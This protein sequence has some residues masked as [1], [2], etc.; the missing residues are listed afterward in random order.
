MSLIL[1]LG[2]TLAFSWLLAGRSTPLVYAG[3]YPVTNTDAGGLGSLRRAILDA[4]A[5]P[6]PDTITFDP[7]VTGTIVL[8][9]ALPPIDDDLTIAGPGMSHLDVSGDDAHRVFEIASG[10]AVT[11]TGLTVRDGRVGP[12]N[13]GGI[14][15]AGWLYLDSVRVVSN[16]ARSPS[17]YSRGAGIYVW[18]GS[19]TLIRTQ[20]VSNSADFGGGIYVRTGA[21]DCSG[22]AIEG[23][24][25][26]DGAGVHVD[27]GRAT[28][29]G[30]HLVGNSASWDGGGIYVWEGSAVLTETRVISNAAETGGGLTLGSI[31]GTLSVSGGA[32][33]SN[34][35]S[36]DDFGGNGGGIYVREGNASLSGTEVANNSALYSGDEAEGGGNGG[37]ICVYRGSVVL[38]GVRVTSN[39]AASVGDG[40]NGGGVYVSQGSVTVRETQVVSNSASGDGIGGHGGGLYAE[41]SSVT[42][43]G[44]RVASNSAH[45]NRGG[46]I[47]WDGGVLSV[48]R[49]EIDD[50]S[51]SYGGGAHIRAGSATLSGTHLVGNSATN[52]G[53]IYLATAHAAITVTN[54]CIVYNT[55]TAVVNDLSGTLNAGDNWWGTTDGP[56][57]VGPGG[58]DSV[59]VDVTYRPFKTRRPAGCAAYPP[60]LAITKSVTPTTEVAYHTTFTYTVTLNN[61][62]GL[63]DTHV[64]LTDTLSSKVDFHAWVVSPTGTTQSDDEIAWS[65]PLAAGEALTWTWVV[66]HMGNYWDVVTNAAQFS[67]TLEAGQSDVLS[68]RLE[69]YAL[70]LPVVARN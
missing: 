36:S 38:D 20:V 68:T 46:G 22:G 15:S 14:W 51:A 39:S 25:A 17:P 65:G 57:G 53:G 52:G 59:G 9:A 12:G 6:G 43:S 1:G 8:T 31:S 37:G 28:L 11:I 70:Y 48:S 41:G 13:G 29:T 3:T 60:D 23:N 50:N 63:S 61:T 47:H 69:P 24:S 42:L 7:T 32:I 66:V 5:N 18:G 56:S 4:N 30:T 62:G 16:T 64:L 40:G 67:G 45:G 35:A 26:A 10:T 2:L 33:S 19:V 58:G 44:T 34:L 54:G 55:D 49:G 21:M 27:E